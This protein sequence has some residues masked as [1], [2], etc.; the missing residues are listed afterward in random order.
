MFPGSDPSADLR[1]SGGGRYF[2]HGSSLEPSSSVSSEA[3]VSM[4]GSRSMP[5]AAWACAVTAGMPSV[6]PL[7]HPTPDIPDRWSSHEDSHPALDRV[8]SRLT[9]D[10]LIRQV[11]QGGGNMPAYGKNLR[12][13]EATALVAFLQTLHPVDELPARD[14]AQTRR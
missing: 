2:D 12:P 13:P 11:I 1:I 4:S 8:A 5:P 14:T 9:Q 3:W 7:H 10:E 6:D